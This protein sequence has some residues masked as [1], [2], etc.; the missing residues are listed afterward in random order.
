MNSLIALSRLVVL[1]GL[2]LLI[3]CGAL[4]A[5]TNTANEAL[6]AK[7]KEGIDLQRLAEKATTKDEKIAYYKKAIE[8]YSEVAK[9]E[10]KFYP[11]Q[12]LWA[13]SLLMIVLANPDEPNVRP[14]IDAAR[15]RFAAA[16]NCGFE[17]WKLHYDWGLLLAEEFHVI[18][19][20][21]EELQAV[22]VEAAQHFKKSL[23]ITTARTDKSLVLQNWALCLIKMAATREKPAEQ[24]VYYRQAL[25]KFD[26]A[27]ESSESAMNSHALGKWGAALLQ[28]SKLQ[29]DKG[30]LM[31]AIEKLEASLA[32]DVN[33]WETRYNLACGYALKG[34]P[35]KAM[36]ELRV[37]LGDDPKRIIYNTALHD[38]DLNSLRHIP[39]FIKTFPESQPVA[40]APHKSSPVVPVPPRAK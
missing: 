3:T 38:P 35:D 39:E 6:V 40:P 31:L 32:N 18:G 28:Y 33:N 24:A 20:S 21:R 34:E 14:I 36:D 16:A 29:Q 17:D 1:I 26:L 5:Q 2:S 4:L 25:A 37:C 8:Q 27:N 30:M 19:Q 22:L 15:E 12:I 11:A 13:H 23:E 7:F 9:R 10:P